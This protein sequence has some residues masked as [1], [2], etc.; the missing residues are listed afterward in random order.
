MSDEQTD[1]EDFSIEPFHPG[2]PSRFI[3]PDHWGQVVRST[4]PCDVGSVC[5]VEVPARLH[6]SVLDMNRFGV[7]SPGGGGIGFAV[8]LYNRVRVELTTGRG[9]ASSGT[10]TGIASHFAELFQTMLGSGTGINIEV[11]DHGHRHLGLGSSIGVI[12]ATAVALNEITGRPLS[13]RNL[14]KLIAYNYCEEAAE[15]PT[16]LIA[17]FETNVGAMAGIHGGMV[18]ASDDCELICRIPMPQNISTLLILPT[19]APTVAAGGEE[20]KALLT[21]ARDFDSSETFYKGYRV[22]MDLL[23]AMKRGDLSTIGDVIFDLAHMGSK[24]AECQLHGHNGE[25][26]YLLLHKLKKEGAQIVCMSSVGPTV[27]A[28]SNDAA[29]VAS[30]AK[31]DQSSLS[32]TRMVIPID[33]VGARV[34]LD[35]VPVSY[36]YEPWWADGT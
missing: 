14:R 18:V 27:F 4:K 24:K 1:V 34:R 31:W 5:E 2:D 15:D 29:V 17:G 19:L 22:L 21:I 16:M 25:E 9:I 30:W 20:A 32:R 35:G 3:F 11:G 10:R 36:L 23:P 26:I 6:A 28:M 12:T 13:L 33:N 7:G 8:A